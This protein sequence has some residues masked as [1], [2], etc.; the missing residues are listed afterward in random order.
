MKSR[1]NTIT[2]YLLQIRISHQ[3]L[4]NLFCGVAS[5]TDCPHNKRLASVHISGGEYLV[6][7]G[8]MLSRCLIYI[9]SCI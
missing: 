7:I 1:N 8:R 4:V 3:V 9:G 5:L 6:D 2:A